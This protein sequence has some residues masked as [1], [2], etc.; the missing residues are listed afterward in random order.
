MLHLINTI[1]PIFA[2]IV[3]GWFLRTRGLLPPH[4]LAPLNRIVY[5][6]A[7][8]AMI[9]REV[10]AADFHS[11]FNLPLLCS[12]L[13][14]LVAL[15]LL[16]FLTI[17]VMAIPA[18]SAGTFLQTSFHGNLGYIGLAVAFYFLGDQG[19][20][21]ASM[22]AGFI[23]ILQNLLAVLA[24]Q[25]FNE[26]IRGPGKTWFFGK[27]IL[28]NPV[29]CSALAGMVFSIL[30]IPVPAIFDRGLKILSGMALPTAL[31][32]IGASLS[33]ELIR[34]HFKL[35]VGSGAF[36][37]MALPF[38]GLVGYQWLGIPSNQ[39][40][41]GLILLACPPATIAYVMATEMKGAPD[42]ATAAVS[43]NTLGSCLTFIFW[44]ALFV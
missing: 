42:L 43:M 38:L 10:A 1:I 8:P 44:L 27:K 3:L 28:G 19:L 23:M 30:S 21:T 31:L 5:Y 14:P 13:L 9:F 34:S 32:I 25:W 12:T 17:K 33:F 18:P 22:M 41:P 20:R 4:L 35:A 36:K 2:V 37:L 29:V 26:G 24:L 40:L 15:F 16:A 39:F 11:H 7:I 6:F